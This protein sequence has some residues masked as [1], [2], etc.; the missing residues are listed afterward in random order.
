MVTNSYEK[1]RERCFPSS[2]QCRFHV[3]KRMTALRNAGREVLVEPGQRHTTV[4]VL[5]GSLEIGLPGMRGEE[6]VTACCR[7]ISPGK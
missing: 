5:A 4:V 3:L 6:L 7:A 2:R 1:R